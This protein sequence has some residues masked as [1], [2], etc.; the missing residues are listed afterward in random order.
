MILV[1][2]NLNIGSNPWVCGLDANGICLFVI[3]AVKPIVIHVTTLIQFIGVIWYF[4]LILKTK[5]IIR[6]GMFQKTI[7]FYVGF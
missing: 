3:E 1:C 2:R 5:A 6:F 7:I 4:T